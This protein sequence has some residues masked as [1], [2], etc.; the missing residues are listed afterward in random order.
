MSGSNKKVISKK[1]L[2]P[3]IISNNNIL[4]CYTVLIQLEIMTKAISLKLDP[5]LLKSTNE[6][7][8]EMDISRNRYINEAIAAYNKMKKKDWMTQQLKKELP[9]IQEE[10][11]NVL[12]EMEGLDPHLLGEWEGDIS[13]YLD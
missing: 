1:I 10:S 2:H 6:I 11:M 13:E 12:K 5:N 7:V 8:A 3:C 4:L 9:L